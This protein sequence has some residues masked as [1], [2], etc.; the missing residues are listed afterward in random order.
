M[1]G[2][3]WARWAASA[4]LLFVV[5]LVVS[6]LMLHTPSSGDSAAKIG[7]YYT[8]HKT[9]VDVSGLL[10]YLAVFTG[11]WFFVWLW[12]YYRSFP[13]QQ[14]TAAVALVGAVLF[15]ISGT[16]TAG[17]DFA[18]ADHTKKLNDGALVALNQ[19]Q[20]DLTYPMT[21]VGLSLLF[22]ASGIVIY[23][24]RAFPRWLAWVSWVLAL[25]ALV[26]VVAFF[27]FLATPI[28]VLIISVLLFRMPAGTLTAEQPVSTSL[29]P[30]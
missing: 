28:W 18:F 7:H 9:V 15:A 5:F 11:V 23:R 17:I 2:T 25:V 1:T 10:T 19:L 30:G 20:A 4:G 26:P 24:A 6:F 13:G 16:L 8:K 29:L 21:I 3:R 14:V 12:S 22:T 27:A